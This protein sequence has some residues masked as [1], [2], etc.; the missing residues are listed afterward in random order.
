TQRSLG[1]GQRVEIAPAAELAAEHRE[2]AEIAAL[3]DE[4]S[5]PDVAELLPADRFRE[6][7]ELLPDHTDVVIAADEDLAP[8]LR[9]HWDDV[10][11]AFHDTGA[12]H[13][14]VNPETITA[15]L[16]ARTPL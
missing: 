3:E 9:D 4:E 10:C 15:T 16:E 13:L 2:L 7:L 14:Y 8:A 5:R 12:H 11:A 6:L 1:E